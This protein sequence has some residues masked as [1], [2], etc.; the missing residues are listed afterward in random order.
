MCQVWELRP[1][2]LAYA[3]KASQGGA[4]GPEPKAMEARLRKEGLPAELRV[5]LRAH[6]DLMGEEGD[7]KEE[8]GAGKAGKEVPTAMKEAVR[9]APPAPPPHPS[10]AAPPPPTLGP[11]ACHAPTL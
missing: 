2:H 5:Q 11:R 6:S 10:P 9:D 8:G 7:E 4:P 1:E 3:V